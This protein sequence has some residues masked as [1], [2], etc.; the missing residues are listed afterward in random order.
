MTRPWFSLKLNPATVRRM[1]R[2]EYYAAYR[3]TR[4]VRRILLSQFP[5]PP[6]YSDLLVRGISLRQVYAWDCHT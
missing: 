1:T 2:D 3:W 5:E 4:L 6:D